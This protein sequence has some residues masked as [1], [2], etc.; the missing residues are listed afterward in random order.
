M[1]SGLQKPR[2]TS[3]NFRNIYKSQNIL[4]NLSS[5]SNE[6]LT[7]GKS[8]IKY[9]NEVDYRIEIKNRLYLRAC[10]LHTETTRESLK[11]MQT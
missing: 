3:C 2:K 10:T 11:S 4:T 5:K 9:N 6:C 1:K 7:L 8:R